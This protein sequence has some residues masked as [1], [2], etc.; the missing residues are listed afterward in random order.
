MDMPSDY[1]AGELIS[2]IAVVKD[3]L[4]FFC[5]NIIG[6]N[7]YQIGGS[8]I[9]C[10]IAGHAAHRGI[11]G[12]QGSVLLI[13]IPSAEDAGGQIMVPGVNVLLGEFRNMAQL[14]ITEARGF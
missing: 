3:V 12:E 14:D 13:V 4:H 2:G 7:C 5:I 8:E 6:H 10:R 1:S 9:T 11:G